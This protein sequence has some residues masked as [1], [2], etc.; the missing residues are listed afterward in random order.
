MP[1]CP[2]DRLCIHIHPRPLIELKRARSHGILVRTIKA[3]CSYQPYNPPLHDSHVPKTVLVVGVMQRERTSST[4][5]TISTSSTSASVVTSA[6]TLGWTSWCVW[7]WA[8][9]GI[10]V[11]LLTWRLIHLH[12]LITSESIRTI[13]NLSPRVSVIIWAVVIRHA[14]A[15]EIWAGGRGWVG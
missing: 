10:R 7:L 13:N 8:D 1:P 4:I 12:A 9:H 3:R 5:S 15:G 6:V 11:H 14:L 2:H